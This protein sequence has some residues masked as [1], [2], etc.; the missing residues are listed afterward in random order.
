M[1]KSQVVSSKKSPSHI[2]LY[3]VCVSI[4]EENTIEVKQP[5]TGESVYFHVRQWPLIRSLV[6]EFVAQMVVTD[7]NTGNYG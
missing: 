7:A 6:D 2:Y 3:A 4:D 1:S 5:D